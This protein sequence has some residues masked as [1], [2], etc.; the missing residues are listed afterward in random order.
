MFFLF[1]SCLRV[2]EGR[3]D[4]SPCNLTLPSICKKLGTK[5]DG[6]PQH[7]DCKQVFSFFSLSIQCYIFNFPLVIYCLCFTFRF[8]TTL[9]T[10]YELY[11][12]LPQHFSV[13]AADSSVSGN[14]PSPLTP[15]PRAPLH[16]SPFHWS[17]SPPSVSGWNVNHTFKFGKFTRHHRQTKPYWN[18]YSSH[19]E[20]PSTSVCDFTVHNSLHMRDFKPLIPDLSLPDH[21]CKCSFFQ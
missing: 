1:V 3:W 11:W 21:C 17:T 19:L 18:T 9:W 6:K 13:P 14:L 16:L 8:F 10:R 2:Q 15:F 5:N 20:D 7:Q 12:D 4:D